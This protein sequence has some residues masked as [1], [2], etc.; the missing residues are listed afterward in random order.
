MTL[1]APLALAAL[2]VPVAIFLVHWL[3]SAHRRI[4]VPAVFLWADLPQARTGRSKRQ[5]P[6]ISWLLLLQLAAA[7]LAVLALGRPT[8]P[9]DPPRHV[10][11]ILDASATMQA[12]D[13][14][15][16]RFEAARQSAF[17]RVDSLRRS[18][19]VSLIRAGK[20]ATLLASG[21]PDSVRGSLRAAQ[22][23]QSAPAIREALA[24]ASTRLT[25]TPERK[26]QIVLLTDVAWPTPD[27]VGPLAAPVELVPTGGG[28]NNQAVTSLVVRMDPTGRGQT[29]FVE[30]AN[31]SDRPARV[32]MRM[33][34][35]GA[36][37]DERQVDIAARTRA[38]LSIPLPTD[39]HHISVRL[40]GKD[41]L[42]LDD[43]L[44]T[45]A[46]GGPPRD[47]DLLGRV[48]NGLRKAIESVPSLHVRTADA[49][50]PADL[51]V[52]AGVLPGRLPVGPLLLVDPPSNSGRLLGVGLGNGARVQAAHPLLQGLDLVTLQDEAPS[53]TGVPGWAHVVLGTR[54]GPLIMEGTLEG[55]PVV[56]LTFDPAVSGLEK[57]LA[58]PLLISNAT[59]FLL[60]E[61]EHPT[62]SATMLE[63]FDQAESD[64][65]PRPL[66]TFVSSA[67]VESVAAGT[68]ETWP[69]LAAAALALL[70]V[71][72]FVFARRG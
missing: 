24:L 31:E 25:A 2:A 62:V 30:L 61:S 54:Q 13:V 71:E 10:A 55:H 26:G 7:C 60:T 48:S 12:T 72:W 19:L 70:G 50:R 41:A 17:N 6:P 56:T 65:A 33:T 66:P 18:D 21:S 8:A 42:A 46:P 23:G 69:W 43:T 37:I 11:L 32:P 63:P 20:D 57:S 67:P 40:L 4:R 59:S 49:A 34:A 3:F 44:E 28:S 15:P 53:V 51:S 16:T 45:I 64:I 38:R 35:D 29:A 5:I 47:V 58:F 52:L 9:T 36:P 22:P 39:A 14:A 1:L 68:A 27:P